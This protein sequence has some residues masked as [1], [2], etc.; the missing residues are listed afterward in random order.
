VTIGRAAENT[1]RLSDPSVS[2][3]H[4]RISA[5]GGTAVLEDAPLVL[6]GLE[7]TPD[8]GSLPRLSGEQ[9]ATLERFGERRAIRAG[10]PLFGDGRPASDFVVV[11]SGAVAMVDGYGR[12]NRVRTVHGDGRFIG[13]L[14]ILRGEAT[15][16]TPVGA[17]DG[18]VVIVPA[19]RLSAAL[20]ADPPLRDLVLRAY[21]LRRA[22][23]LGLAAELRIVGSGASADTQRLREFATRNDTMHSFIDLDTD[24]R[25]A[26]MLEELGVEPSE[27]P[28]AVTRGRQVLRNPTDDELGRALGLQA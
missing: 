8:D 23:L 14:G 2:R 7:E 16:L 15:L 25:A 4:A 19:D 22:N 21:L 1:V 27:T 12:D 24:E 11:V 5:A 9:I 6:E 13:E 20:D 28:V 26:T 17:R 10:E 3:V 18:E